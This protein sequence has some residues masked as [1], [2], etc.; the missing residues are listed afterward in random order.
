MVFSHRVFLA[1]YYPAFTLV[2]AR[3]ATFNIIVRVKTDEKVEPL[4]AT[5]QSGKRKLLNVLIRTS[6]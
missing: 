6:E 2:E 4:A 5:H 3:L 1:A